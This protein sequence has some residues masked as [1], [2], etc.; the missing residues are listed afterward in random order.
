MTPKDFINYLSGKSF[1]VL[2]SLAIAQA[3]LE[4][5][6]GAKSFYNNI[7]GIKCH[8]VNAYAGCRLGSTS[9]VI[10]G[11]YQ[12]NL[13]LAFQVYDSIDDSIEDYC[14]LMN[15]DRYRPAREATN[16]IEA[17]QAIKDCG[18]ATSINYVN[19]L[20]KIIQKYKLYKL[21]MQDYNITKNFKYSEFICKDGTEVPDQYQ[22][23]MLICA[24]E[25]QLLRDK[26][27]RPITITS[28]YR[29]KNYNQSIGGVRNSYHLKSQACDIKVKGIKPYDLA[30]YAARYTNFNGIGIADSFI[31]L[32]LRNRFTIFKY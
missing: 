23:Y 17:T 11:Q 25:L 26:L 2:K 6:Y 16:Y 3:C 4:S 30:I 24:T 18:Y 15:L 19:S 27:S 5:R 10:N 8:D 1:P 22:N 28:A 20:R 21:D 29:T 7:Y 31:H 12:H 9:E 14:R 13:K 32:D